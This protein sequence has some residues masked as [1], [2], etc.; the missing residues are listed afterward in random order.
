MAAN[1]AQPVKNLRII[2]ENLLS[3]DNNVRGNA[4]IQYEE[5][6]ASE[7]LFLLLALLG[8]DAV[9]L[10]QAELAAVLLRRLITS[11]FDVV[12]AKLMPEVQEGVKTRLLLRLQED[13]NHN[14]RRKIC[15]VAAELARNCIDDDGNNHWPEFLKYLFD[16]AISPD[17]FL[18]EIALLMFASVPGVFG[19]QQGRYI[20]IIRQMLSQCLTDVQSRQVQYVAVKATSNFLLANE[21]EVHVL[22]QFT[23]C[24]N[25]LLQFFSQVLDSKDGQ[26]DEI[27]RH[28]VELVESC[29]QMFRGQLD[30]LLQLCLKGLSSQD[31]EESCHHLSLEV[32]VT[33]C[34]SAPAM[35]K[36]LG[37]KHI[38]TIL[39]LIL[40]M[41][42]EIEEDPKWDFVDDENTDEDSDSS[43]IVAEAS[44]DRLACALGGKTVLPFVLSTLPQMLQ[45]ANWKDRYAGLMAISAIGEG[46]HKQ[47]SIMLPQIVDGVLPFLSDPVSRVRY[48]ACNALG[49]MS[50]DFASLFQKKFHDK[51]I[52]ALL[53]LMSDSSSPRV[54][55]HAGAAL[56]NFF[57][58]CPK[59][60]LSPYMVNIVNALEIVLKATLNDLVEKG[61]KLVLEQVVVTL[62]SL[63][64]SAQEKFID[65]Y[66]KFMP[67]LKHIIQNAN[68][69]VLRLL[70]GKTIECV[71]LIGLAVGKEKFLS[72]ASEVMDLL[73][74]T[75]TA[76]APISEDD[77]QLSYMI[78]AWARICKIL[79]KAFKPY[80]PYVMEPVLKAAS[81]KPEIAVL[82]SDDM[83]VV[84]NDDDWEFVNLGEKHNF[85]IRTAGLDEKATACQMLVCYAKELKEGFA[86]YVD[87]TSGRSC[88]DAYVQEMWRYILPS[89]LHSL[90]SEPE[91][92]VL[93]EHM[94][95]FS[96][97]IEVLNCP[98]LQPE[99]LSNLMNILNKYLV[100]HFERSDEREA[101]RKEEDYDEVLE[102]SLIKEDD[103]DIYLLSKIS[104]IMSILF[105][106]YKE[107][108]FVYFDML[109]P[110]FVRLIEPSRPWP[111]RQW[112]LCVFADV[113]EYSGPA[114]SR[115]Q[116]YFL[117]PLLTSLR[118]EN[119]D[120][121]QTAAY[122]IGILS[123]FGGPE[124]SKFCSECLP[125]LIEVINSPDSRSEENERATEN[126]ISAVTKLMVFNNSYVTLEEVLPAWI[127]W[128]P[129]WEDEEEVRCIYT[130]LCTLLE[131]NNTILLGKENCNLPRIV[132]IIA[133]T[134]LKEAVDA[135]S[136]LGKRLI[137]LLRH[138]QNNTELFSVCVNVLNPNQLEALRLALTAQ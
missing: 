130:F 19:N 117:Q 108:F 35:V 46:C 107:E 51:V 126:A 76:G 104:E 75:Q 81:I 128:L 66:E 10:Q 99:D 64:D 57:E 73:L 109:L 37:G 91:S 20:D 114:C 18:R 11:D 36:K 52:P 44:L 55:A 132:Q 131:A 103:E 42:T 106:T 125:L 86:D 6:N 124:F 85:G 83:K 43:P 95:A 80:L 71:S 34:E 79:G 40:K 62:A 96:Q 54:Q 5:I 22:K 12:F 101:K 119:V 113:I 13:R 88:G 69:P 2:I 16:S 59:N 87:I 111:D 105:S 41:M 48:A 61:T 23:D 123:Q 93:C 120:L 127:T 65:Y 77:P 49:Q 110:H 58:D 25:L 112:S 27:L 82:D 135:S 98:C 32:L 100:G 78:A 1:A 102:E 45:S 30:A 33:I 4:E 94:A 29:P 67:F 92:E 63:A 7:K 47:M 9:P 70:R 24:I 129:V 26:P 116:Q 138:I 14:L 74:K 90:E 136:D 97:C 8:D 15:D 50:S 89:L 68:E 122:T 21:K 133:D 84:G 134:F 118:D 137:T 28:L 31:L 17:P 39:T 3:S 53:Q 60:I 72:D 38:P 115:Y 121:R 56:V